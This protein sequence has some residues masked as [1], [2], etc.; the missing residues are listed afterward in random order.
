MTVGFAPQVQHSEK[1]TATRAPVLVPALIHVDRDTCTARVLNITDTGA[2]LEAN[3]A[4]LPGSR[5][6]FRCGKIE[7]S[8]VVMWYE[9]GAL[10]IRFCQRQSAGAVEQQINRSTALNVRSA[11]RG[12]ADDKRYLL[13]L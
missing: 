3:V 1:R 8:A 10:G 5:V 4:I 13:F 6:L 11:A 7:A 2:R 9:R 12:S